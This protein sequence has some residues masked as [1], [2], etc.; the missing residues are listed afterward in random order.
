MTVYLT[1]FC[2]LK[3]LSL[4]KKILALGTGFAPQR[5]TFVF[6]F[7]SV[8]FHFSS[9]GFHCSRLL[10]VC[11]VGFHLPC[12]STLSESIS[13]QL[14]FIVPFC[15]HF[16]LSTFI[17]P[18]RLL[19][20]RPFL[21]YRLSLIPFALNLPCL[22][23]F[24][25]SVYSVDVCFCPIS[26]PLFSFALSLPC[27]LSFA[28]YVYYIGVHFCPI[29]FHCSP[30]ALR[31]CPVGFHL[32]C[33]SA[34]LALISALLAF[35]VSLRSQ[36]ALSAFICPVRLLCRHLFLPHIGFNCS[37]LDS[38]CSASFHMPCPS[39]LPAS[40]SA[41]LAFIVTLCS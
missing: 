27:R 34:L 36:F 7:C 41:P 33:L 35:I 9:I 37:P 2:C 4:Y 18:V 25:L 14:A 11:P 3:N 26:F 8:G 32:P 5:K 13:A 39:T 40:I 6:C 16:A 24:A 23:S 28:L 30:F 38:V 19:C 20:R 31:V 12:P 17:C 29:G 1:Y 15:S 22:L 21:P 10:S